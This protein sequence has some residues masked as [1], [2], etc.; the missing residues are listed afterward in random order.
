MPSARRMIFAC[1]VRF[2]RFVSAGVS[3]RASGSA[4]AA[5]SMAA[6][7]IGRN[8]LSVFFEVGFLLMSVGAPGRYDSDEVSPLGI[9]YIENSAFNHSD[10]RE[11]LFV[12]IFP[13]VEELQGK[14]IVERTL[15]QF[16][17]DSVFSEVVPGFRLV[18]FKVQI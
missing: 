7:V 15:S 16:K 10:D 13:V 5:R 4:R 6:G 2:M 3:G 17:T 14:R 9:D 18:P 1:G 11:T 12:V 8:P